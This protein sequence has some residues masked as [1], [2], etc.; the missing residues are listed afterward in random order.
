MANYVISPTGNDVT[1]TG[2]S[3][4]PWASVEKFWASASPN[5]VLEARGGTY[6]EAQSRFDTRAG[7]NRVRSGIIIQNYPGETAKFSY[8]PPTADGTYMWQLRSQP[9]LVIRKNPLTAGELQFQF[10]GTQAIETGG[11]GLGSL[12][13]IYFDTCTGGTVDGIRILDA[14]GAGVL[15]NKGA[16]ITVKRSEIQGGANGIR[17][18]GTTRP[19]IEDNDIHDVHRMFQN[20]TTSGTNDHGANGITIGHGTTGAR[21]RRNVIHECWSE[22]GSFD[23]GTDGGAIETYALDPTLQSIIEDNICFNNHGFLETGAQLNVVGYETWTN[24]NV[25]VRRN[26]IFGRG[27]YQPEGTGSGVASTPFLLLRAAPDWTVEHNTWDLTDHSATSGGIRFSAGGTFGGT[28]E[29]LIIRNNALRMRINSQFLNA[30]ALSAWPTNMVWDNNLLFRTAYT[31]GQSGASNATVRSGATYPWSA[32]GLT[33]WRSQT[34]FGDNDK[35]GSDPLFANTSAT[36]MSLRD[37]TPLPGSPLIGAASDGTDIGAVQYDVGTPGAIAA[38]SFGRTGSTLGTADV[39]GPWQQEIQGTGT[40]TTDGSVGRATI[41]GEAQ[42]LRAALWGVNALDFD[43][44]LDFTATPAPSGTDLDMEVMLGGRFATSGDV[45]FG[46]YAGRVV[47]SP[48]GF[49]RGNFN[50]RTPTGVQVGVTSLADFPSPAPPSFFAGSWYRMRVQITGSN[51]TTLRMKCW[52]RSSSEPAAWHFTTTDSAGP[53][54][55]GAP[56][57]RFTGSPTVISFDAFSAIDPGTTVVN[58]TATAQRATTTA[59]A[60]AP[61]GKGG[62][63]RAVPRVA[64][65]TIARAPSGK[66]NATRAV[67]R[68]NSV[69]VARAVSASSDIGAVAQRATVQTV[70]RSPAGSGGASRIIGRATAVA[71][72]RAPVGSG[73]ASTALARAEVQA[74]AKTATA[75]GIPFADAFGRTTSGTADLGTADIGGAWTCSRTG[76]S[77]LLANGSEA[78]ATMVLAG[79]TCV[80]ALLSASQLN[81]EALVRFKTDKVAVGGTQNFLVGLR[82]IALNDGYFAQVQIQTDGTFKGNFVRRVSNV[83]TALFTAA[84]LPSQPPPTYVA[85]TWHRVRFRCTGTNPT[86]LQMKVWRDGDAEPSIW[87]FTDSTDSQ[88]EL[89]VAGGAGFRTNIAGGITN[90]PIVFTV[91]DLSGDYPGVSINATAAVGRANV[92]AIARA[93]SVS[94][95]GIHAIARANV[96]TAARAVTGR[97]DEVAPAQ[98]ASASAVARA[99]QATVT[100]T[101]AVPRVTSAAVARP[102]TATGAAGALGA[103]ATAGWSAVAP[104]ADV[105][106]GATVQRATVG[107]VARSVSAKGD[108]AV[109]AQRATAIWLPTAPAEILADVTALSG[110]ATARWR[111]ASSRDTFDRSIAAGWGT[112]P[113]GGDWE[114]QVQPVDYASVDG[115]RGLIVASDST[116]VRLAVVGSYELLQDVRVK[117]SADKPIAGATQSPRVLPRAVTLGDYYR[118]RVDVQTT[119]QIRLVWEK[120]VGNSASVLQTGSDLF[121][122]TFGDVLEIR[123]RASGAGPTLLEGKVWRQGDPEPAWQATVPDSTAALQVAGR[124]GLQFRTAVGTTNWP[125]TAAF[126]DF[127]STSADHT[128]LTTVVALPARAAVTLVGRPPLGSAGA[129]VAVPRSL[130]TW[131]ARSPSASGA[132]PVVANA[133]RAVVAWQGRSPAGSASASMSLARATAVWIGRS[134]AGS[135]DVSAQATRVV[136][137]WQARA[138]GVSAGVAVP[139]SRASAAWEG[140]SPTGSVSIVRTLQRATTTWVARSPSVS[141]D[142]VIAT[143]R[144]TATWVSRSPAASA[145][146]AGTA[147]AARAVTTW[148]PRAPAASGSVGA[149]AGRAAASWVARSIAAS[150]GQASTAAVGRAI[151]T[152]QGRGPMATGTG[153]AN[154]L[155]ARATVSWVA[156]S[157]VGRGTASAASGRASAAWVARS[158]GALGGRPLSPPFVRARGRRVPPRMR[159][160]SRT[161]PF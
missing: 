42:L 125:V 20:D 148:A 124:V 135:V 100:Q 37:Y 17:C 59:V 16:D 95:G 38:D 63:T 3:A 57:I 141:T 97:V 19:V 147:L 24:G 152:W 73:A 27:D 48:T 96:V 138:P 121:A 130:A 131:V 156:R 61:V 39:G 25:I 53:Q 119:N 129:L 101:G 68:V 89:Q 22:V 14:L 123:A 140:R 21:V 76:T 107:V 11:G 111:G 35:W 77:T 28:L 60:R 82:Q 127:Q 154:A 114:W 62:A 71:G 88:A 83:Q 8:A 103:R 47:I 151:A 133:A 66:G 98:R 106:P 160:S 10:T 12:A 85:G 40:L 99:A 32:T 86:T 142:V 13:V 145:G 80:G 93:P 7:S 23:Y 44:T 110:R 150:G 90:A 108:A 70:G 69:V 36:D 58:A 157:A 51:P 126:R 149:F 18:Y 43:E 79:A 91:D 30:N 34:A 109:D 4:N 120:G 104:E 46:G 116:L 49:F 1:G 118:L 56:G 84:A 139:A 134:A 113:F 74:T 31:L 65:T 122:Y 128:A 137:S 33:N 136:G 81:A 87:H 41:T 54:T 155:A 15:I 2:S 67:P 161:G 159:V 143:E 153:P 55:A 52:R 105:A 94:A 72:A 102:G 6:S 112:A 64:S 45:D 29:N 92:S 146:T 115:P 78:V 144:A 50:Y 26:R 117:W 132:G 5:N 75:R 158:P 9:N